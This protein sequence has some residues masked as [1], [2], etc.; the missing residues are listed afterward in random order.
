MP[1]DPAI[2]RDMPPRARTILLADEDT[3]VAATLQAPLERHGFQLCAVYSAQAMAQ[4]LARR[5]VDLVLMESRL[6]D[7][8][9]FALTQQLHQQL[10]IP[11][12]ILSAHAQVY[13]RIIGLECGA[14]DYM[15]KPFEPREVVAR[16]RAVLRIRPVHAALGGHPAL[17]TR[18]PE[19]VVAAHWRIDKD[20]SC[21]YVEGGLAVALSPR[22]YRLLEI[23]LRM[24]GRLLT[25]E[26]LR[27]QVHGQNT[28]VAERNIDLLVARLRHKLGRVPQGVNAIRTVRGK[29]YL[30]RAQA[31]DAPPPQRRAVAAVQLPELPVSPWNA[32]AR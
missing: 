6:P 17:R 25:R 32:P 29:G 16:I 22:E 12:I 2:A 11:V 30:L 14:D 9:G 13:D 8:D 20:S 7:G 10:G 28:R 18:Q 21:L 5:H 3:T 19:E 24:P 27:W 31:A 1:G 26:Q 4:L 23:F 15:A